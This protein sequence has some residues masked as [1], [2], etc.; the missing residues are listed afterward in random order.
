[1]ED[2]VIREVFGIEIKISGAGSIRRLEPTGTWVAER[3]VRSRRTPDASTP[4][5][6]SLRIRPWPIRISVGTRENHPLHPFEP[7][8]TAELGRFRARHFLMEK[9]CQTKLLGLPIVQ[10]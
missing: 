4:Y 10:N 5:G 7:T 3:V 9:P 6:V 2:T 1:M 8:A